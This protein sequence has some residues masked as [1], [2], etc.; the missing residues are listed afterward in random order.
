V[1]ECYI[2]NILILIFV[3]EAG[4]LSNVSVLYFYRIIGKMKL[5]LEKHV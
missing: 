3:Y 5:L 1:V 4:I 2:I